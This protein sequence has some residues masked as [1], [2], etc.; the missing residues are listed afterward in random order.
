MI[1]S[2]PTIFSWPVGEETFD[3]FISVLGFEARATH[4]A[5]LVAGRSSNRIA[6]AFKE[7]QVGSFLSNRDWYLSN[8]F[9]I[10]P[11]KSQVFQS[12]LRTTLLTTEASEDRD[13]RICV[14]IS[15]MSRPM[16]AEVIYCMSMLGKPIEVQFIYSP[17]IFSPPTNLPEPVLTRGPVIPEYAGWSTRPELPTTLVLG[18]GYEYTR[19]LGA[20][21][22]LEPSEA[23]IF[24]PTGSDDRFDRA[25]RTVNADLANA[26]IPA[27]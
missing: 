5:K 15:S 20:F 23:W 18:I 3:L 12:T 4:A 10:Q 26:V 19:A 13:L 6:F 17:A 27:T 7:R 16:L 11:F 14:D 1:E 9:A 25:V 8:E 2:A 22:Y 24:S 21:E